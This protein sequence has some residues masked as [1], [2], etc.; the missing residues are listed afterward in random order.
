MLPGLGWFAG[1][2]LLAHLMYLSMYLWAAT[3][4]NRRSRQIG[5]GITVV[6]LIAGA[7]AP[8]LYLGKLE[9]LKWMS[10]IPFTAPVAAPLR[11]FA[12]QAEWWEGLISLAAVLVLGLILFALASSAYRRN[13]LRGSGRGGKKAKAKGE[14]AKSSK[15][16]GSGSA[17]STASVESDTSDDEDAEADAAEAG[18]PAKAGSKAKAGSTSRGK[19]SDSQ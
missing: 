17:K 13:L 15:K 2:Y 7:I 4:A 12:A 9:V 10:W 6:L 8:L 11:F 1:L 16:S 18:A 19:K 3:S 5:Y 14:D